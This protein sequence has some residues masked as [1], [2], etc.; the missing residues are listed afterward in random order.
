MNVINPNEVIGPQDWYDRIQWYLELGL[1]LRG[2]RL[3]HYDQRDI[4]QAVDDEMEHTAGLG[5][6][7]HVTDDDEQENEPARD[8]DAPIWRREV[9]VDRVEF[10]RD[11]FVPTHREVDSRGRKYRGVRAGDGRQQPCE[12]QQADPDTGDPKRPKATS[13]TS[14]TGVVLSPRTSQ[15]TTPIR[16]II[17]IPYI[18][19][20]MRTLPTTAKGR[21]CPGF[22]SSSATVVIFANP[23]NETNTN[24]VAG[25]IA[26]ALPASAGKNGCSVET[27]VCRNPRSK[28]TSGCRQGSSR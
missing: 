9:G 27:S 23:R 17:M 5:E 7:L 16:T 21:F 22:F 12:R 13:A 14:S 8:G 18:T 20:T 19:V 15:V 24:P 1:V 2:I 4:E 26:P 3:P 25:R 10:V 11:E 28:T 6:R